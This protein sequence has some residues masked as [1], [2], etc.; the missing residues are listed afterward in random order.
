[1]RRTILAALAV[2]LAVGTA[3]SASAVWIDTTVHY[4]RSGYRQNALWPWPYVCPD[5]AAVREPFAIMVD[6]GWRRQNLLGPHHFDAAK[7]TLTTAG[8]LKIHWIMTQAPPERRQIFVERSLDS[9]VTAQRI[10]AARQFAAQVVNDG[11]TPQVG[12]THL[13]SEGRPAAAVDATYTRFN[14]SLPPP[15]LPAPSAA[16]SLSQ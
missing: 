2:A 6:N 5:R 4:V 15:V 12:D 3:S 10:E 8:E 14:E 16:S 1:M 9:A 13:V 11:R 7:G